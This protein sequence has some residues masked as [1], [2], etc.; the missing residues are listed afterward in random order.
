MASCDSSVGAG[1]SEC[2]LVIF[3][4]KKN[5]ACNHPTQPLQISC[6]ERW[7]TPGGPDPLHPRGTG[8]AC[9][10]D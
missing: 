6:D 1:G 2:Y 5:N 3:I 7:V 10:N 9:F 4:L 8:T